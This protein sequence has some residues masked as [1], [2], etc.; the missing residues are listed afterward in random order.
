MHNLDLDKQHFLP[1][2]FICK[3]FPGFV[4]LYGLVITW[5]QLSAEEGRRINCSSKFTLNSIRRQC[6]HLLNKSHW[7]H[8]NSSYHSARGRSMVVTRTL[9]ISCT[10]NC[11]WGSGLGGSPP[12]VEVQMAKF[13]DKGKGKYIWNLA[14]NLM[15]SSL[16]GET[17]TL[18]QV[19]RNIGKNYLPGNLQH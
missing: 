6:S 3:R 13:D 2:E 16:A 12:K 11:S 7:R 4:R 14:R 10:N 5:F 8:I 17:Q 1:K 15:L 18:W 9:V 19:C